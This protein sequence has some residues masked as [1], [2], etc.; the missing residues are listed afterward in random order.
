MIVSGAVWGHHALKLLL[1]KSSGKDSL[2]RAC[3]DDHVTA[4][5]VSEGWFKDP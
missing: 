4:R 3:P 2:P 5:L 1:G